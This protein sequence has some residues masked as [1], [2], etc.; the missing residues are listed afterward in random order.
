MKVFCISLESKKDTWPAIVSKIR[1]QGIRNVEMFPAVNGKAM[2]S[3]LE[4]YLSTWAWK[5][6][7]FGEGRKYHAELT[8]WGAVGCYLSHMSLWTMLANDA[9]E[10]EYL[11][12]EDD[13]SFD[14]EFAQTFPKVLA[15]VPSKYDIVYLDAFW[16]EKTE[17]IQGNEYI[18][19]MLGQ[20][21][22][23]HAYIISKQGA[24]KFLQGALP[25][26]IQVD[27]FMGMYAQR[28]KMQS[29]VSAK[30]L[31]G[32]TVH[33]SSI[34]KPCLLCFV[35]HKRIIKWSIGAVCVLIVAVI[36]TYV[37]S[38]MACKRKCNL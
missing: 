35:T 37:C 29:Y 31:C 27:S 8:S 19:V 11:I 5:K 20:F 6:L 25:I 33:V 10:D 9:E 3:K 32:Q 34:Q 2:S 23:T 30:K 36:A 18:N 38:I 17:T 21:F 24:K 1:E 4:P 14:T 16:S 22:G 28:A 15:H 26:E 12:F 13:V 7:T